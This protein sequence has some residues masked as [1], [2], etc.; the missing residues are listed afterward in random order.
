[1]ARYSNKNFINAAGKARRPLLLSLLLGFGLAGCGSGNL[2]DLQ[3]YAE[4]TK[5]KPPG[6]IAPLP[7]IKPQPTFIYSATQAR[8][9]FT[10]SVDE[11]QDT[12]P[13][14]GIQPDPNHIKEPLLDYPLDALRMVGTVERGGEHW[15][16]VQAPDGMVY[17]VQPNN[18]MGQ[19]Y[20]KVVRVSDDA[21]EL[22][23]IIEDGQGGWMER[24]A[25]LALS[26]ETETAGG[27]KK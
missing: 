5:A 2:A 14:N 8:D 21:I 9:P 19:N 4:Q 10:P 13:K 1:M 23:E 3:Q 7:E 22:V 6:K 27:T 11:V 17:R 26:E 15:S 12:G 16:L 24:S 20:G 25:S 18:Y